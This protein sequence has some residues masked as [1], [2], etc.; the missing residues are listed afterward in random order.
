M[1][2]TFTQP[3]HPQPATGLWRT[4]VVASTSLITVF[5]ASAAPIPVFNVYRAENGLTTADLSLSVVAYFA[6]TILALLC[7]GRLANH[8]GRRPA[9]MATLLVMLV[10]CVVL[11]DVTGLGMLIAGRFLMGIGAGMASSALT[12]YIVDAAPGQP[13]WLAPAVTSQAPMV[14]L[15]VGSIASGALVQYLPGARVWVF[16][17]MGLLLAGCLLLMVG[18]RESGEPTPGVWRSLRPTVS[19]PPRARPLLPVAL[20]VFAATWALGAFYQSFVPTIARDQL[21]SDNALV[22]SLLFAAYMAPGVAGAPLV[23][24]LRPATAQR[25]GMVTFLLGVAGILASLAAASVPL[26]TVSTV[27]ASLGQGMAV[28]ASM[29]A[30]LQGST[31][32]ERPSLMAAIYLACYTGAMVPSI[33][34]GQLSHYLG[35]VTIALG[36]GVLALVSTGIT[37]ICARNPS[38]A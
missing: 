2:R 7:L 11:L 36:Y 4:F 27:V 24:R 9:A 32:A 35:T 29:R 13:G 16:V 15:T 8:V 5:A 21:N 33:I 26:L 38:D 20:S 17:L 6:G 19:V 30:L 37:L 10:G 31:F 14:G 25:L 3:L 1:N 22:V 34:A 28:S 23:G 18:C 12:T